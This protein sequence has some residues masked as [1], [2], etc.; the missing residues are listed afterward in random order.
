[1]ENR[2]RQ[3]FNS[4]ELPFCQNVYIQK[5]H[6]HSC[7]YASFSANA[8]IIH[9]SA[10]CKCRL[11]D[12]NIPTLSETLFGIWKAPLV[13]E[14]HP[15]L[16]LIQLPVVLLWEKNNKNPFCRLGLRPWCCVCMLFLVNIIT[17]KTFFFVYSQQKPNKWWFF[18]N[19]I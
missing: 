8:K 12:F 9:F 4:G 17:D 3:S 5:M 13:E 15:V 11:P 18:P 7:G 1:M 6:N 19:F 16:S 10:K 2:L 14:P